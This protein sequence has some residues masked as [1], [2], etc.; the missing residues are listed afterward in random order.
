MVEALD[1]AT[2]P[3]FPVSDVIAHKVVLYP[4]ILGCNFNDS[5]PCQHHQWL[6]PSGLFPS[7]KLGE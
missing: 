7:P 1:G 2:A 3:T 5:P 4:L 6:F